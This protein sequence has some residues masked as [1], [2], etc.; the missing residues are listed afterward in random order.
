M[1]LGNPF[2]KLFGQSPFEPPFIEAT[3]KGDWEEATACRQ[4][5]AELEDQADAM[6]SAIRINLPKNLFLP[7]PRSDLLDMLSI[8]DRIANCAKDISGLM[9]GRKMAFP[10]AISADM[11]EY[12]KESIATSAQALKAIN[13]LDE[14]LETGFSGRE[15]KVVESMIEELDRLESHSDKL[16][17]SIRGALF[18]VES[19]L[20]PVDAMFLYK[21]IERVGDLADRAQQVGSR[22]EVLIAR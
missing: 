13:E 9:L 16:Q 21:I 19:E 1:A 12:I 18:S 20:P 5:I 14:L 3:I 7:V 8:Q 2:G 10:A 22:L 11:L 6:K 4:H 15:L 17:I